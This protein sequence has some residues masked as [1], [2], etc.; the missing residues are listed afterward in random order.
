MIT[1]SRRRLLTG[2]AGLLVAGVLAQVLPASLA[3]ASPPLAAAVAPSA[4]FRAI[5]VR[6]TAFDQPDALLSQRLYSW[7]HDHF[8]LLDSQLDTL[9][10][11]LQQ[12]P[13]ANGS[14][15]LT[16]LAA[17][18]KALNDLY[19]ALVSGWY[20]GVVGPLPRPQC[21][22]FENI[23]SYRLVRDS[24]LPPSY[25]PGQPDFWTQP[26]ARRAHV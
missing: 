15:L 4:S 5:S 8:P 21:I 14:A 1:L 3:F 2:T 17:Q 26:P 23:A 7:L 10:T 9:N 18:P 24:L 6:L 12:Q 19:Q 11:L 25:A 16:L 22:A 13:D 20:L